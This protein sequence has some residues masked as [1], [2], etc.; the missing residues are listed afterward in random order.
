M[1]VPGGEEKELNT[2]R[3]GD[4]LLDRDGGKMGGGSERGGRG[5]RCLGSPYRKGAYV[6]DVWYMQIICKPKLLF[7]GGLRG[8]SS[9][10]A[11]RFTDSGGKGSSAPGQGRA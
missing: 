5:S 2:R 6:N 10:L 11:R 7:V 4:H 8:A 9:G 1:A 3:F